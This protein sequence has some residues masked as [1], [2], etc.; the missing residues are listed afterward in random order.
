MITLVMMVKNEAKTIQRTLESVLPYVDRVLMAD[1]GS[2]DGTQ[3]IFRK[4]LRDWEIACQLG[5]WVWGQ[6][7]WKDYAT[8]RNEALQE[9]HRQFGHVTDWFLML[10]GDSVLHGG[11]ELRRILSTELRGQVAA[12]E[13]VVSLTAEKLGCLAIE[14]RLGTLSYPMRRVFRADQLKQWVYMGKVHEAPTHLAG[15]HKDRPICI[16][17]VHVEYLGTDTGDKMKQWQQHVGL[18]LSEVRDG[19]ETNRTWFYLGQTHACLG[20]W[21]AAYAAYLHRWELTCP[22]SDKDEDWYTMLQLAWVCQEQGRPQEAS[23]WAHACTE[24]R[25]W[26]AEGWY[27]QA[28]ICA[29]VGA[30][31]Q[32]FDLTFKAD[33]CRLPGKNEDSYL[34]QTEVYRWKVQ[35]LHTLAAFHLDMGALLTKEMFQSLL[36]LDLPAGERL[37]VQQM[38]AT[39]EG[40]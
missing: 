15:Y 2:T 10:D 29:D 13:Q 5:M 9:A 24:A 36:R 16:P 38:I 3:E 32:V 1:T 23:E 21:D 17:G 14:A 20:D 25:P 37:Y 35:L 34:I 8:N 40:R 4:V 39:L 18:L 30:W 19:T 6:F 27:R 26:R 31:D 28:L 33:K 11:K 12:T 22:D 7:P